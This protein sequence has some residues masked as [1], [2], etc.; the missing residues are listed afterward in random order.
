MRPRRRWPGATRTETPTPSVTD[1]P[2]ALHPSQRLPTVR[3]SCARA[4]TARSLFSFS[5]KQ[6]KNGDDVESR[7][8][9]SRDPT[10]LEQACVP[11]S[12]RTGG[13]SRQ[14]E[15]APPPPP[16]LTPQQCCPQNGRCAACVSQCGAPHHPGTTTRLL[17]EQRH[18]CAH[19][20][21]PT[22][23]LLH[24]ENGTA[25]RCLSQA[26]GQRAIERWQVRQAPPPKKGTRASN[27]DRWLVLDSSSGRAACFGR[28][29]FLT[30][31]LLRG[32]SGRV[33]AR[34]S[35]GRVAA[36][37]SG[38]TVRSAL[39]TGG[40]R[41]PRAANGHRRRRVAPAERHEARR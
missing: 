6:R 13:S 10:L 34:G 40:R 12:C 30:A 33:A 17:P 15:G 19:P 27:R 22:K 18:S 21:A 5:K 20:E 39:L 3:V 28:R 8:S 26:R 37:G 16:P 1:A 29:C 23:P 2:P 35:S 24:P 7:V 11:S 9:H 38:T 25:T 14:A 32:R 4:R 31:E 36:R 41:A